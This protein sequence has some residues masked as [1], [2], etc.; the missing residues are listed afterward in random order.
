MIH[1]VPG[2][3]SFLQLEDPK[4]KAVNLLRKAAAAAKSKGLKKLAEEIRNYEGPFDKIKAM[5]QK[6]IFRLMS[7]QKDE[8]DHKNWCDG[9]LE[10][11]EE[12]KTD[13]DEK[14][15]MFNKKI[16]ELDAAVKKLVK[17]ITDNNKKAADIQSYT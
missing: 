5:I 14:V 3:V 12:S 1:N 6:M 10:K 8:D 11:S 13:K 15:N 2:V 17:Q 9:E 7:E 4:T 16:N